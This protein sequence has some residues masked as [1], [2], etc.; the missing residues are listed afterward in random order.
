[1][2]SKRGSRELEGPAQVRLQAVAAPDATDGRGT[3]PQVL[4]Q[5]AGAPVGGVDGLVV[6][7]GVQDARLHLSRNGGGPTRARRVL[8]KRIDACVQKPLTPQRHLAAIKTRLDRDVLVLPALGGK[9]DYE[10]TLLESGLHAPALGQH[11]KLPRG[12][13]VQF[14]RLGNPHRSSL[15]GD[16]SMPWQLSSITSRALH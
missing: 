10:R 12:A 1:L 9:Q 7:R 11:T 15:L 14:N 8:A 13:L 5:R 4:G 16:W 6:Q 3:Q 2:S